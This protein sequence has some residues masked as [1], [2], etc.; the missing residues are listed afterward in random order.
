MYVYLMI[1]VVAPRPL[2]RLFHSLSARV[3]DFLIL[4]QRFDYSHSDISNLAK[5]PPRSLQRILP[6][7]IEEKLILRTRKSGKAY[8]YIFNRNS[9]KGKALQ[10][11]FEETI[12]NDIDKI[13]NSSSDTIIDTYQQD[14][15]EN[16][17]NTDNKQ[18]V[19]YNDTERE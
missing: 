5:I 4:N 11:Y 15:I 16:V 18:I 2:E 9:E 17:V 8:M 13:S 7:L 10:K 1:E 3:L 19:T 6:T 12:K 14:L